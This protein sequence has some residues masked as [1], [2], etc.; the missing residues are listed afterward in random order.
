[1]ILEGKDSYIDILMVYLDLEMTFI[2]F[3]L[4][5]EEKNMF[6]IVFL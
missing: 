5:V 1:M 6:N 3:M 2:L 4:V